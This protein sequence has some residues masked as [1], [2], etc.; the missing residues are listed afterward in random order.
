MTRS[1]CAK[2]KGGYTWSSNASGERWRKQLASEKI[3]THRLRTNWVNDIWYN[4]LIMAW[5]GLLIR[6]V[7]FMGNRRPKALTQMDRAC[8]SPD[9]KWIFQDDVRI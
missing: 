5:G 3:V 9:A 7:E 2:A 4:D 1:Q 6:S 8:S